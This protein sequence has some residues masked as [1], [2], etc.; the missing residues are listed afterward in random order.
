MEDSRR[1]RIEPGASVVGADGHLGRIVR[2]EADAIEVA[3]DPS[4]QQLFIPH[5]LIQRVGDDGSVEVSTSRAEIQR[6]TSGTRRVTTET[7]KTGADMTFDC[8]PT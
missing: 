4:G 6:L 5:H 7:S 2:V 8:S 3:L 1:S